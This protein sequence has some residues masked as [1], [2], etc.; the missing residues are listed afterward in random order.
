MEVSVHDFYSDAFC[1]EI[2]YGLYGPLVDTGHLVVG[3]SADM[4]D[5]GTDV[6]SRCGSAAAASV[7]GG[8]VLC[9]WRT[10]A[11]A[12]AAGRVCGNVGCKG[13]PTGTAWQ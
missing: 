12:R 4:P 11:A 13:W 7:I 1:R 5:F 10:A 8:G 3:T 2:L 9:C 6:V